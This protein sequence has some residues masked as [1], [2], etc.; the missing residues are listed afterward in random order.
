MQRAEEDTA[1]LNALWLFM[2]PLQDE[3]VEKA[4]TFDFLLLLLFNVSRL[5]ENEMCDIMA[6]HLH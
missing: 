1:L 5:S 3:H 2:N 4:T 6:K